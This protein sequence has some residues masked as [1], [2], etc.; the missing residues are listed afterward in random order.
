MKKSLLV[1]I[2]GMLLVACTKHD[3]ILPELP[4]ASEA[5]KHPD[6]AQFLEAVINKIQDSSMYTV[7]E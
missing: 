7:G 6:K 1:I 3:D 5:A 2:C 4:K